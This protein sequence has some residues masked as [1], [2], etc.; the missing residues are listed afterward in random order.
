MC[1]HES[2]CGFTTAQTFLQLAE[3][4]QSNGKVFREHHNGNALNNQLLA[5]LEVGHEIE[6]PTSVA[7]SWQNFMGSPTGKLGR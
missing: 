5:P 7:N 6:S 1:L 2:S 3:Q 4:A